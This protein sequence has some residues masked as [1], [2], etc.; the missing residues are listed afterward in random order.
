M[1]TRDAH[2][3]CCSTALLVAEPADTEECPDRSLSPAHRSRLLTHQAYLKRVL[4]HPFHVAFVISV[5][6]FSVFT[7]SFWVLPLMFLAEIV[8]GGVVSS[9]R[10]FRRLV[11]NETQVNRLMLPAKQRANLVA[12]MSD[13]HRKELERIEMQVANI[14]ENCNSEG[15]MLVEQPTDLSLLIRA[16]AD[17]A[18][19]HQA[20]AAALAAMDRGALLEELRVLDHTEPFSDKL[21]KLVSRRRDIVR[22]RLVWWNQNAQAMKEIEHQLATIVSLVG[23]L[24]E[25]SI[26]QSQAIW[27]TDEVDRIVDH[28]ERREQALLE[29]QP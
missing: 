23:L 2:L 29:L 25:K 3:M 1:A 6:M 28:I 18:S 21:T 10:S 16:Y 13:E 9:S 14:C 24:H 15:D 22:R 20:H 17:L 8:L 4:I 11:D 19:E 7:K 27:T 12:Q 5:V 26:V